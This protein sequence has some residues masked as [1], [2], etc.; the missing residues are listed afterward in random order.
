MPRAR[1]AVPDT[2]YVI[3]RDYRSRWDGHVCKVIAGPHLER[4]VAAGEIAVFEPTG[5]VVPAEVDHETREGNRPKTVE[6]A[7]YRRVRT[8]LFKPLAPFS[9]V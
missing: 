9:L 1:R 4:S 7:V 2:S 6:A 5:D 8:R 3:L